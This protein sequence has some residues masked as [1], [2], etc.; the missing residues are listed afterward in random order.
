MKNSQVL[1]PPF[2]TYCSKRM[3]EGLHNAGTIL[4]RMTSI[5]LRDQ[6]GKNLLTLMT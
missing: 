3:V 4:V 6:I 2:G 5:V 1:S